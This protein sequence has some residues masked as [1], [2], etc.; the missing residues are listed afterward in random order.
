MQGSRLRS[1]RA[2]IVTS[3]AMA[4]TTAFADTTWQLGAGT[5]GDWFAPVNWTNGVP[6][7]SDNASINNGGTATV[8]SGLATDNSLTLGDG[9]GQTGSIALSGGDLVTTNSI[10]SAPSTVFVGKSGTGNITQTG[11][12]N[13]ISQT[14]IDTKSY[15]ALG[16]Q[17]GGVGT[18]SL[19]GTGTLA[20]R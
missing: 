14:G 2:A 5:P 18:Y 4:A 3:F 1:V 7:S 20:A 8:N 15:L 19:S 16:S 9:V 11:G 6:G 17:P 10:N 13:E 12:L